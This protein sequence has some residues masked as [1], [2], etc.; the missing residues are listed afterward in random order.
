MQHQLSLENIPFG[1]IEK[2]NSYIKYLNS[3]EKELNILQSK[4]IK[5]KLTTFKKKIL[6]DWWM[7]AKEALEN[8]VVDEYVLIHCDFNNYNETIDGEIFSR[9][10]ILPLNA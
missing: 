2:I 10:P 7:T 8:K 5:M 1:E 9:C 6:T 3:L 4:K